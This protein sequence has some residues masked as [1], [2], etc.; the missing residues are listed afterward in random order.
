MLGCQGYCIDHEVAL[1][2]KSRP[3]KQH[4]TSK[5]PPKHTRTLYKWDGVSAVP[6]AALK[7][8]NPVPF[9]GEWAGHP[10]TDL[11]S[12]HALIQA[13]RP[14]KPTVYLAGDSSLDNKA[15]VPPSGPGG[16]P[17]PTA[18]PDIYKSLLDPPRPKPD[19]AFWLNHLLGQKATGL[20]AAV[21]ASL[22]RQRDTALMA[23]DEF[24]RDHI[25]SEDILIVS[26]GANDIALSPTAATMRHMFQ[27]AWLT[28]R[29]SIERGTAS[30]LGYFK[31]MFN[32]QTKAYISRMIDKQKPRAVIISM[33][34][35]PLEAGA[36]A[37]PSWA[38]TQLKALGYGRY[39]SQLQAAIKKLYEQATST[40]EIE[41]TIV[42]P[43]ALYEAMDGKNKEDYVA[44]VEPSVQGG[45]K[46]AELLNAKLEGVLSKPATSKGR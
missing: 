23:H 28:P 32:D 1:M 4:R 31:R 7:K 29:S 24:I 39:P 11:S 15:W 10:L 2:S 44:R 16:E 5:T 30:S 18:V 33:I 46:M 45:K 22:L 42:V 35:F 20:N 19:V 8:I 3:S 12:L 43:C 40:I 37:Q 21:E 26:V 6:M 36:G 38:D 41:G 14:G 34:Y 27:L 13:E 25:R 9:Y 17:L